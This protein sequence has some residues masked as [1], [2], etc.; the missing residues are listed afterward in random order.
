MTA[1]C[2]FH[3]HGHCKF[4][5]QCVK[6]HTDVTCNSFPCED[7]Q[8]SKHHPRLCK[9]YA[10]YGRCMFAERCSF[11]HYSFGNGDQGLFKYRVIS[12]GGRGGYLK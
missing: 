10:T 8:C 4:A 2:Q 6:I 7:R 5:A 3:Q 12:R 11:L 1:I 9:Y